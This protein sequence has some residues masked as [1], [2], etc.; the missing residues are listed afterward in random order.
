MSATRYSLEKER[1]IKEKL[2]EQMLSVEKEYGMDEEE[3]LT[4][5]EKVV[6]WLYEDFG[7]QV[8]EDWEEIKDVVIN[9]REI[10]SRDLAVFMVTEGVKVDE[11][12]WLDQ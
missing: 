5:I 6:E 1:K 4:L 7:I 12:L 10:K 3:G 11:S 2:L 8:N 9:R